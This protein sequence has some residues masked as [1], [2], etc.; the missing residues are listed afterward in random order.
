[1]TITRVTTSKHHVLQ[2]DQWSDVGWESGRHF[3]PQ[4][5]VRRWPVV[6]NLTVNPR[7]R[8]HGGARANHH[9]LAAAVHTTHPG[10]LSPYLA[11]PKPKQS[12][13]TTAHS[14]GE[15]L[16]GSSG[17]LPLR[18]LDG[19]TIRSPYGELPDAVA[20]MV[21]APPREIRTDAA[22]AMVACSWRRAPLWRSDEEQ[23]WR[24]R[25]PRRGDGGKQWSFQ[26]FS[27]SFFCN[28]YAK[29]F[30]HICFLFFR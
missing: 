1:M 20:A 22:V 18:R 11:I 15:L 25:A 3:Q 16:E 2:R 13:S 12:R 4:G 7:L 9:H 28:F 17:E 10:I 8:A 19:T 14:L 24:W 29:D 5:W 21:W 6:R 30:T 23:G 27:F 26:L